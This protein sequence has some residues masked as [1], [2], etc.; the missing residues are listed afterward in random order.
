M[1]YRLSA[2][3][4]LIL[5]CLLPLSASWEQMETEHTRIIFEQQDLE[6]ARHLASFADEVY[7]ELA[8]FLSYSEKAKVPVILSGRTAWANG[9][10]T[11]FPNAVYLYLTSPEDRFLGSR[12]SDWLYSLFVHELTH[13]LHLGSYVG[14]AKYLRFLGPGV[15]SL[16]TVFMPGWWIEGI[17]TYTETE[18]AD[19][20]RGDD[21]SFALTYQRS[22]E[23]GNLWSLSQGAYNGPFTPSSRIYITGYL[24]VEHLIRNYGIES[25]LEI[26]RRF[27]AFPF[28]GLS[29][30]FKRVTGYPAKDIFTFALQE[31]QRAFDDFVGTPVVPQPEGSSYLLAP[32]SRGLLGY[33]TSPGSGG[34]LYR[35]AEDGE[36]TH[37]MDLSLDGG[38]AISFASDSAL[39]SSLWV[40]STH[41]S[42]LSKAP[43]G[44][45]DLYLLDLNTLDMVKVTDRQRL[46]HPSISGDGKRAVAS[47]ING[48]FYELVEVDLS[49]GTLA[50]LASKE[51]VSYLE[52]ALNAEGSAVV[53]L[54]LE[55][56]NSSLVLMR[57]DEEP[58]ELVGPTSDELRSPTWDGEDAILFC[59]E[60]SLHRYD[61]TTGTIT[62]L[63]SEPGGVHAARRI[64]DTLYYESYTSTG[65][66]LYEVPVARLGTEDA[67]FSDPQPRAIL[68]DLPIF[69]YKPYADHLKWNLI[70]P[71]PFVENNRFQPGVWFHTTSLLHT[72]SLIGSV[73]WSFRSN[74]PVANLTYQHLVGGKAL[75]INALLNQYHPLKKTEE[76]RV[77]TALILPLYLTSTPR[78]GVRVSMQPSLALYWDSQEAVGA[79]TLSLAS[80]IQESVQRS[81][82]FFGPSYLASSVGIQ[83]QTPLEFNQVHLLTLFSNTAQV[84]LAH[85]SAM[86]RM[87]VDVM[88]SSMGQLSDKL[89][90]FSFAPLGN[91]DAK[92]RASLA[93]RMPLGLH[94]IPV[95]YGGLTG[96]GFEV[97]AMSAWYLEGGDLSWEGAWAVGAT[98]TGNFVLGGPQVSFRPFVSTSYLVGKDAF[99]VSIGLDGQSFLSF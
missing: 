48:P 98:L 57:R 69:S 58:T 42:Y 18:F 97:S 90:L 87:G 6:H 92:L 82:D 47:R 33:A 25:F 15:T 45:S 14:P 99:S 74:L 46:V 63:L 20:G 50:V 73:G 61:L 68:T 65:L 71:F 62:Q 19:G 86:L 40:D 94:D 9:Y 43:V 32:T 3:L 11:T 66:K 31:K 79:A 1:K 81:L 60:L 64:G 49:D 75:Q 56:G 76:N 26:N 29:P 2:L 37:L 95:A 53:V 17:T 39:F 96:S 88:T 30:A 34:V 83:A 8:L 16:S 7:E 52:S 77:S 85:T 67:A 54:A 22:L 78:Y 12:A 51:G 91:G 55:A 38:K 72:Q 84:R 5:F 44:Y 23:E 28:F 36:R 70:L 24:M 41:P 80:S 21:A 27:A 59:K 89:P 93:L 35:Y 10:Y 13:Y 4:L